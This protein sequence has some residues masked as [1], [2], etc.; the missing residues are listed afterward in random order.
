MEF[1]LDL[2]YL[3]LYINNLYPNGVAIE[4]P[5]WII[6]GTIGLWFSVRLIKRER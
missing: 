1:Y 5:T 6:V 3:S 2:E 4:I